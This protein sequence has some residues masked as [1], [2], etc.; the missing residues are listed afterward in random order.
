MGCYNQQPPINQQ[1]F[2]QFAMTLN[3]NALAQFAQQA[4]T[5]GISEADIKTGIDFI[6]SLKKK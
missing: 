4:R 2:I 5:Q 3:D 1:Q 6:N